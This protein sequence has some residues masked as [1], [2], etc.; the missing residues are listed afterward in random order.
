VIGACRA[1]KLPRGTGGSLRLRLTLKS[2]YGVKGATIG[3][4]GEEAELFRADKLAY[5]RRALLN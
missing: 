3:S 2:G 1:G 5:W 4:R